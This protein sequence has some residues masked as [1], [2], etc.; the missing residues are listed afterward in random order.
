MM[1]ATPASPRT[2]HLTPMVVAPEGSTP[3]TRPW[4]VTDPPTGAVAS[5]GVTSV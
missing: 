5:A 1:L 3:T 4:N 2:L